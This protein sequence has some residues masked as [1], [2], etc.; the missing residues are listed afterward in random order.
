MSKR[1]K[2]LL[3]ERAGL[4][5][6]AKAIFE[7]ADTE[8]REL[9]DAEKQRDD[10][11]DA[12]LVAITSD[13][14]REERRREHERSVGAAT[15][16]NRAVVSQM[17]VRAED[18]PRRGFANLGEFALAVRGASVPGGQLDERLRIGA[19]P[20]NY[21]QETGS[22]EGRMVPPQFRQEIFEVVTEMG[23][24]LEEVD[25]EP[26][27]GNSVEFL[28]DE[29][30]PW[31]AT[32]VQA[33]WRAEATQME[34]SKL[35]TGGEQMRLHELY[36]FVTATDEL[37]QDA[38]RLNARLT[39]RAGLAIRYKSNEAIVNGTG[40]GQPLGWMRSGALVTVSKESGQ[41][42]ATIVAANVAKMYSRARNPGR[43]VWYANP[44]VLPQ[45]M[46]MTLGN[47]PIWT[48]PASGFVNAPGG[49]LLGRPVRFIDQ[50]E[51]LGTKGDL[52]LVDPLGYY[53]ITKEGG[54]EFASSIHL[55]FDYGLQAFRWTFRLNGQPFLSAP[56][57]PAKGSATRSDFVV[58]ETRS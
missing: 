38:P 7:R 54:V 55:Y 36:A 16:P 30:T 19:A 31:G 1:Y 9:T 43:T 40:V 15:D 29:T 11:I 50:A 57:S 12:R 52:Q 34:P 33:K 22:G 14:Q 25:S 32:G 6:E 21:H 45:L 56:V 39:Q 37:L 44:D 23:S 28:R 3:D 10:A 18:D 13:I 46:L 53:A 49:F 27:S 24:L 4:I 26:T 5:A 58:L 41:A 20:T 48:P 47:Q 8:G 42:A 51:T 35:V 2:A 17:H